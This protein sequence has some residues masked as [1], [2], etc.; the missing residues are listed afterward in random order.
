[1]RTSRNTTSATTRIGT[2]GNS[3]FSFST[4]ASTG[5]ED[6]EEAEDSGRD[7]LL[8][9]SDSEEASEKELL[10]GRSEGAADEAEAGVETALEEDAGTDAADEEAGVLLE[11]EVPAAGSRRVSL[12]T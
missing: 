9:D 12:M 6:P 5:W 1:M 3:P 2:K 4:G 10:S 11:E 8:S 7:A